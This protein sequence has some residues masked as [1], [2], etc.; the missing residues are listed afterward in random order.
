[1]I[2]SLLWTVGLFALLSIVWTTWRYGI[3]PTPTAPRVKQTLFAHLPQELTGTIYELGAG[4]GTLAFSLAYRYPQAQ[5]IAIEI[6]PLP[7]FWM[8][9][10][11][12]WAPRPNLTLIWG[13]LFQ[14]DLKDAKL[15]ICYLFPGAMQPLEQKILKECSHPLVVTHTFAFPHLAPISKTYCSDLYE[16][17]IYLYQLGKLK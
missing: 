11:Q 10:K 16:T 5:I 6:S 17:P 8:V 2:L 15:I 3:G 12:K 1:M 4:W 13:D 9:L 7:Y 14:I